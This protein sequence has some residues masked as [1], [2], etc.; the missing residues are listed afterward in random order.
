MSQPIRIELPF[1][2]EDGS[3]NVYLFRKPEAVLVDAGY[4]DAASWTALEAGLADHG[5]TAADLSRVII[6]HPHVDHYGLAARIAE[7][8]PARICMA[9]VGVDWLR[10]FPTLWRQRIAYYRDDF[11]PGLG[12]TPA[13]AAAMLGWM[14]QTLAAWTPIPADRICAFPADEPLMLGGQRWQALH[15]PGHN[16]WQMAFYQP[17][18]RQLISSDAL[19]IPT[20]TPVVDAPPPGQ[21][22]PPALPQMMASLAQLAALDVETVFPG[23]GAPFGEHRAVIRGQLAR[24]R[25]RADECLHHV[26]AGAATVA[27]LFTR[28][29]G[30]RAARVGAAGLWMAVGYLDL[31]VAEG[32]LAAER[33]AASGAWRY[34]LPSATALSNT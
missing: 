24:I 32:R 18:R 12:L 31:L 33:G 16:A 34:R 14:E 2:L 20:A 15:L 7:A 1:T 11:L 19:M 28:L 21:P 4:G 5:L 25:S 27:D 9:N 22:R 10:H 30:D 13:H 17:E 29:Y 3:V 26:Q 8:G 6:T 23:H